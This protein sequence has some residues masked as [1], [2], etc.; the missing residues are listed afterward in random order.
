MRER[1]IERVGVKTFL[2]EVYKNSHC[3]IKKN[4]LKIH[5]KRKEKQFEIIAKKHICLAKDVGR[6]K[7][8]AK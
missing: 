3:G 8:E 2:N 4:I 7:S 6:N 1:E 5:K